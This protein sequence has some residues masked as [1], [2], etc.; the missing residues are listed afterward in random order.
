MKGKYKR[1]KILFKKDELPYLRTYVGSE[2]LM[3][4][5][6]EAD[7][8]AFYREEEVVGEIIIDLTKIEDLEQFMEELVSGRF[9]D[10]WK[11]FKEDEENE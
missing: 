7:G 1:F 6:V 10:S 9:V 11:W 8:E 5:I 2:E 4:R 3:K